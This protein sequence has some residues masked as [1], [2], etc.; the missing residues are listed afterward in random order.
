MLLRDLGLVL[1]GAGVA[2]LAQWLI[3]WATSRREKEAERRERARARA[4][5]QQENLI[6]AQLAAEEFYHA[7]VIFTAKIHNLNTSALGLS[8]LDME[9]VHLRLRLALARIEDQELVV[10]V[11]TWR[12]EYFADMT[13]ASGQ[14]EWPGDVVSSAREKLTDISQQ[15]GAQAREALSDAN[16]NRLLS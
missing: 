2:L 14:P 1:G 4:E 5:F 6:A 9:E 15:L 13:R 3:H 7:M 16:I 11:D 10:K 12:K 8:A